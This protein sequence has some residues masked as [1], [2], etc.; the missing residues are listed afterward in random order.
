MLAIVAGLG[1]FALAL[2]LALA[3]QMI[4]ESGCAKKRLEAEER[5][6]KEAARMQGARQDLD[7]KLVCALAGTDPVPRAIAEWKEG[8]AKVLTVIGRS[9]SDWDMAAVGDWKEERF[10]DETRKIANESGKAR[11]VIWASAIVGGSIIATAVWAAVS[12]NY[13]PTN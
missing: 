2:V 12:G 6:E 11:A 8:V 3:A 10:D 1:C 13:F 4:H 9:P 7:E 5:L